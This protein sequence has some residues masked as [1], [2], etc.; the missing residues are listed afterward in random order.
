MYSRKARADAT[1]S[2]FNYE[3]GEKTIWLFAR[4]SL[5]APLL[6]FFST[7]HNFIVAPKIDQRLTDWVTRCHWLLASLVG[8]RDDGFG[9]WVVA[10]E[11]LTK[12]DWISRFG[13]GPMDQ[14]W[15][16][17]CRTM[18]WSPNVGC[19]KNRLHVGRSFAQKDQTMLKHVLGVLGPHG[20]LC[21]HLVCPLQ[22]QSLI[23]WLR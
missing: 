8:P 5:F 10:S 1:G 14:L 11:G 4:R 7:L 21:G 20:A 2:L 13:S 19:W 17:R 23:S 16:T 15:S 22:K 12:S 18:T 6:G 3:K 9:C